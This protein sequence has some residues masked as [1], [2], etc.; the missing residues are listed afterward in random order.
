LCGRCHSA[1]LAGVLRVWRGVDAT[2]RSSKGLVSYEAAHEAGISDDDSEEE[3][4]A[5]AREC[6][7]CRCMH[8]VLC[9]YSFEGICSCYLSGTRVGRAVHPIVVSTFDCVNGK[10]VHVPRS[11]SCRLF[12]R[13]V[14]RKPELRVRNPWFQY[15]SSENPFCH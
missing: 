9:M 2:G 12:A 5:L 3:V 13:R 1:W 11:E 15:G 8:C 4:L 14:S 6:D 7:V 10:R